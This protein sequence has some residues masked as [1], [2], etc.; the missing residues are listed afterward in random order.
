[1]RGAEIRGEL[2]NRLSGAPLPGAHVSL[3][4][5]ALDTISDAAGRFTHRGIAAGTYLLHVRAIGHVAGTW[6]IVLAEGEVLERTFLLDAAYELD[7]IVVEGIADRRLAEFEARRRKGRG[8]FITADE[9]RE[10]GAKRLSEVLR[11]TP[12]VRMI[13]RASGC[14]VRMARA[15]R[16]C[17]PDYVVDGYPASYST[18]PEMPL[19]GVIGIEVYRTLSETP[20]QFLRA[21]NKCGTIVIWTKVGS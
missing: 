2:K 16:E 1:E 12:G 10:R 21:D 14:L 17:P 19:T 9:I 4:G 11:T 13:C 18:F 5:A 7:P 20:L 3:V 8:H 6:V 15:P